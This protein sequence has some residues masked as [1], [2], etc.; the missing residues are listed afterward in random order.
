MA[1]VILVPTDGSPEAQQALDV[2]LPMATACGFT[3]SLL[4]ARDDHGTESDLQTHLEALARARCEP[5]N[6]PWTVQTPDAQPVEA[7]LN[8]AA[9]DDVQFIVMTTHGRS[10]FHR[11]RLGSVADRIVHTS[12]HPV[13]LVRPHEDVQVGTSF[14]RILVPLDGSEMSAR[15][16]PHAVMLAR[17][18]NATIVLLRA[19]AGTVPALA[20]PLDGYY[21]EA[22]ESAEA[23][24]VQELQSVAETLEGVEVEILAT[25]GRPEAV[26][27]E[28]AENADLIVM[29]SHGRGG[30]ARLALGSVTDSVIRHAGRPVMIVPSRDAE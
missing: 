29:A 5:L 17:A 24:A 11:W 13:V 16:I 1:N 21:L 4:S 2:A 14:D 6:V 7:I 20:L 26:I 10:G 30:L 25:C 18:G 8:A 3:V 19:V 9:D 27:G 23:Q 12:T 15:A 22:D 28:A